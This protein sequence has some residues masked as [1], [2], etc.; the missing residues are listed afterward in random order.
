VEEALCF[1][2]IASIVKTLDRDRTVQ[3][4]SPRRPKAKYSQ[5]NIERLRALV[6]RKK[7]V[8]EVRES[9]KDVLREKFVIPPDILKAIQADKQTW[10]NFQKFS[11][12][13]KRIRVAY[14]EGARARPAEFRKRLKNFIQ[15]THRNKMFGYGGIDRHY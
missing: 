2:W 15:M 3:R 5:A 11:A 4:F 6:A 9:L 1:G 8:R 14:I 13:Y 12:S 10:K 7:V